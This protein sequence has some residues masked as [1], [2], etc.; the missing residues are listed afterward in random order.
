M[1]EEETRGQGRGV[2]E[3]VEDDERQKRPRGVHK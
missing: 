2:G 1:G 3:G